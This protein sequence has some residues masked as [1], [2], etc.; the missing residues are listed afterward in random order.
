M[1]F[2]TLTGHEPYPHQI[3]TYEAL[4]KISSLSP[5][6]ERDRACPELVEGVRGKYVILR[7]PTGSGKSDIFHCDIMFMH[8]NLSEEIAC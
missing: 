3:E 5:L 4:A 8:I 7:A 2:K 1:Q 6:R